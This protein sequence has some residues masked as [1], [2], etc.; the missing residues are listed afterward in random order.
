MKM[1]AA[2]AAAL[3]V[4]A[5]VF[6][7]IATASQT[8]PAGERVRLYVF[9]GGILESDP[10]RYQ[11]TAQEVGVTQLAVAAYLVVHPK[12]V[13]LWD[14]GAVADDE[15]TAT[16][17]PVERR[18]VL[19]DGRERR[20]T[21]T[22]PLLPQVLSS[23]R[24]PKEVTH[25]ALSHF[26]WD[27]TAN[28]NAFA[29]ATWLVRQAERD[30]MFAAEPGGALRTNTYDALRNSRTVV[31]TADEHDVFGDG[32]V[33]I[34][35]APG[36]TPG[37]QVLYVALEE[38]G[39]IVLSGDLYHYVQE[40]TLGR[41]PTFEFDTDQTR[42]ARAAVETFLARTNA[43]LW[44]QHDLNAHQALRKAPEFYQ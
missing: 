28:A 32:K 31:I 16:G 34:K 24:A 25:L 19:S 2:A 29:G 1:L 17:N 27:H 15:W 38:T 44:I 35:A 8:R 22:R 26:H 5:S 36:H 39:P 10:T 30:V 11:L 23:G 37:H 20:V 40:R 42:R 33:I 41:L 9:D 13:L 4:G 43:R 18:F 21:L 3:V 12:G 6:G 14:A 7:A